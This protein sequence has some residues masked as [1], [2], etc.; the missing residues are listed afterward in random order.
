MIAQ[1]TIKDYPSIVKPITTKKQLDLCLPDTH[2]QEM[3]Q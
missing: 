1:K 2:I 3:L